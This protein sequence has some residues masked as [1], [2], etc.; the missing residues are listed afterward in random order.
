LIDHDTIALGLRELSSADPQIAAAI[1]RIGSP[2]PR[3]RPAGFETLMS[4]I[5]SQQLST[6]SAQAIKRRVVA[7]L[8]EEVTPERLLSESDASLRAAGLS[9]RKIEYIK[10]LA[11]AITEGRFTPAALHRLEDWE[12][13][14]ALTQLRGFGRW[15]AEIYLMFSLGRKDIFPA[16]DLALRIALGRLRQ[17][18]QKPT[19]AQAR[20]LTEH[21]S[22]WR[23]VGSLFLW[24]YY[25]GAP[26]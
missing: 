6:E 15:S 3:V 26:D 5:I 21:W 10:G 25:R 12:A 2:Q 14:E 11:A 7:L 22:P 16:D 24:H 8:Q 17:L 1:A 20:K 4:T 19:P 13:V 23:T 18:P 9:F